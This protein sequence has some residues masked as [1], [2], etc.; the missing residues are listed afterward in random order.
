M[1]IDIRALWTSTL[2]LLG[3]RDLP[4]PYGNPY[5]PP[6]GHPYHPPTRTSTPST[7]T[8]STTPFTPS[9]STTSTTTPVIPSTTPSSTRVSSTSTP[10]SSTSTPVIPSSTASPTLPSS[11]LITT[12]TTMRFLSSTL[13]ST[14]TVFVTITSAL[15]QEDVIPS[16]IEG[17]SDCAQGVLFPLL[18]NSQCN[19][20]D[21]PCI[22]VELTRLQ[23]EAAVD[24]TCTDDDVDQF[25]DFQAGQCGTQ[26]AQNLPPPAVIANVTNGTKTTTIPV[27]PLTTSNATIPVG[28]GSVVPPP[29]PVTLVLPTVGPSGEPATYTT[30][31]YGEPE[32]TAAP[33]FEG[34]GVGSRIGWGGAAA[35]LVGLMGIVF[36]EL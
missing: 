19:P 16:A 2:P 29:A 27:I 21:F 13:T 17:L 11:T 25:L 26:A 10:I 3:L 6:Y 35:G 36:A 20:A 12:T 28:N 32:A 4:Y 15:P 5:V 18:A 34:A 24:A 23:A 33:T 8:S 14:L 30:E 22:C 31:V 7:R 9:S 1:H